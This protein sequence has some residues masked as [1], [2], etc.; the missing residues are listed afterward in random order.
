MSSDAP[1][2]YTYTSSQ[3]TVP[4]TTTI[5]GNNNMYPNVEVTIDQ[6]VMQQPMQQVIQQ[7]IQQTGYPQ[8]QPIQTVGYPQQQQQPMQTV[9]QQQPMQQTYVTNQPY[10]QQAYGQPYGQPYGV[11]VQQPVMMTGV[12]PAMVPSMVPGVMVM[13]Q[14]PPHPIKSTWIIMESGVRY[15]CCGARQF[16]GYIQLGG[17]RCCYLRNDYGCCTTC[18]IIT[19]CLFFLLFFILAVVYATYGSEYTVTGT[20]VLTAVNSTFCIYDNCEN[21][22]CDSGYGYQYTYDFEPSCASDITL[23]KTQS[24]SGNTAEYTE[25][26]VG[27]AT[28][29]CYENKACTM[30]GWKSSSYYYGE[31]G[32]FFTISMIL[33]IS[34]TIHL[35]IYCFAYRP[36]FYKQYCCYTEP[37][38]IN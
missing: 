38:S 23:T 1:Q 18:A 20:C 16:I 10:V 19:K 7:P 21:S 26:E 24:C 37:A 34:I 32:Y 30:V 11:V 2:A 4:Q 36:Y 28:R 33:L 25:S 31:F 35:R 22:V 27:I 8:Q 5:S 3:S 29:T 15:G 6:Q 9:Y 14:Q 17:C 13:A 12:M